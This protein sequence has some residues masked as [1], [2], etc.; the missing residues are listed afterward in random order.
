M[1]LELPYG[2]ALMM[3]AAMVLA[4]LGY[5]EWARRPAAAASPL[6]FMAL[7]LSLVTSVR[8][9]F[10]SLA[11]ESAASG[12]P[13]R[14]RACPV[15][16]VSARRSVR[17]PPP[18]PFTSP[19]ALVCAA[20]VPPTGNRTTA[21]GAVK[22]F[23]VRQCLRRTREHHDARMAVT[24]RVDP[25]PGGRDVLISDARPGLGPVPTPPAGL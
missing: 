18:P 15:R 1:V 14:W 17:G 11:S 25:E 10:L 2:A 6:P 9:A 23:V 13:W 4:A 22:A 20:C 7:L 5:A 24:L 12:V 8:L 21:G 3:Q 19:A 16:P